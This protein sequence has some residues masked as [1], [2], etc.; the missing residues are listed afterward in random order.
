MMM[1]VRAFVLASALFGA[2]AAGA[3]EKDR[4]SSDRPDFLTGPDVVGKGRFQIETGPLVQ[5]DDAAGQT[6][7]RTLMTPTLLRLGV[8]DK[9]ELQLETDGRVRER[10]TDLPTQTTVYEQGY[11]DTALAV[12]WHAREG[13][14]D[15]AP[16]IGWV[17]Q[18]KM[19]SGSRAFRGKGVRP[20]V[21]GA[22]EWELSN[23]MDLAVNAGLTY[24]NIEAEGRFL[25]ATLG[26]GLG[27]ALT[28]RLA[29]AAEIVA[30]QIAQKKYGGNVAIF[31][32]GVTYLLTRNVLLDALVGG[33]L[34]DESPKYL[35]TVGISVRF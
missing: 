13:T 4:I 12:K 5:R 31:D 23:D 20:G 27:R 26:A 22:F 24:D 14:A 6:R 7:T 32:V 11:A 25:S 9:V 19:P 29:V 10:E 28:Q 18:A 15:G 8:S 34:T 35:F 3:Q 2:V 1:P 16:G 30:Q 21:L 17:F 33:G